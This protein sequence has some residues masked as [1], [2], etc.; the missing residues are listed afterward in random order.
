MLDG[1]FFL[2]GLEVEIDAAVVIFAE[3]GVQRG[4]EFA[5]RFAVPGHQFREEQSGDGGVAF[6]KIEAGADAAAFFAADQDVLLEH[7]LADVFEA[8]G[9]FVELAA[10]FGGELVDE[11]GDGESFG[12]VAGEIAGSG[13]VPDEQGENLVRIDERAVAIDGADAVAVAVGAEAG[14]VFSGA[15]GLAQRVDVRLDGFGM[16]AAEARIARA[17][18]FVAGDAVAAEKFEEQAG[19]GAVHG[20]GDEAKFGV[21]NALPVDEFFDGVE[22][23]SARIERLNQIFARGERRNAVALN[24]RRVRFRF[25]RRWKATRCCRSWLCT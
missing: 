11:L 22:I 19:G 20:V 16:D 7:E 4:E 1:F 17:A 18:N 9:D 5:E 8:D 2:A 3:F 6:G 10:E 23:R 14:V 13:E 15:H 25:A 24:V 12:D 21:A